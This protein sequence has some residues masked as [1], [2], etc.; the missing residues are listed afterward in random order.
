[1]IR[2]L[3]K[4]VLLECSLQNELQQE[5]SQRCGTLIPT[6]TVHR[7]DSKGSPALMHIAGTY[8]M[9]TIDFYVQPIHTYIHMIRVSLTWPT[10]RSGTQNPV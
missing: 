10:L 1:M 3:I 6:V 4:H 7:Y 8:D 5:R 2:P 9:F